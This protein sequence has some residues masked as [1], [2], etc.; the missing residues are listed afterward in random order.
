[1]K[2]EVRKTRNGLDIS[3]DN[4]KGEKD[5]L[6]KAFRDCQEGRCSCPTEEYKKLKSLQIED[7]VDQ[8]Q[9]HLQSLQVARLNL[10]EI[11]NCMEYTTKRVK[12]N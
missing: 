7:H 8:I 2:Y 4:V 9:L 1:M 5:N 10:D 6:L 11:K 3:I 12:E